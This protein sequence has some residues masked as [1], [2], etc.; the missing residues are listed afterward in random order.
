MANRSTGHG[1]RA[2]GWTLALAVLALWSCGTPEERYRTLSIF[3]DDVPLPESMRPTALE[4]DGSRVA[5]SVVTHAPFANEQC[6]DCHGEVGK[7]TMSLEGYSGVTSNVCL[8]CHEGKPTEHPIMHGPVAA[9][10]CLACHEAHESR[11]AHLLKRASPTLCLECH[12]GAE[13]QA[14]GAPEHADLTV[15]CLTCHSGHGS[16]LPYFL[17]APIA[18]EA[19]PEDQPA[20]QEA[21]AAA[22]DEPEAGS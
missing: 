5:I 3:F 21:P 12:I 18:P 4:A 1:Y 7:F 2:A 11:Y 16:A 10:E 9:G 22:A 19:P 20:E 15:D 13:V 8:K 6:S 14:S 17:H